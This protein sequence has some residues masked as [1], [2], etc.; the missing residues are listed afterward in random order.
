M[1]QCYQLTQTEL[2]N[3]LAAGYTLVGGPFNSQDECNQNCGSASGSAG[4]GSAGSG[5][6][7]SGGGSGGGG[8]GGGMS[9]YS[10][11][12]SGYGGYG[13]MFV[14]PV[15]EFYDSLPNNETDMP[16]VYHR[17]NIITSPKCCNNDLP[18]VLYLTIEHIVDGKSETLVL[19]GDGSMW[20]YGD[21]PDW[22]FSCVQT[23]E[24]VLSG[25]NKLRRITN[26][27]QCENVN[28]PMWSFKS[29]KINIT[30]T[31]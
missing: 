9:G 30:I 28:N 27:C 23:G 14:E 1:P 8:S 18:K 10:A 31:G 21:T 5:G 7:G 16:K 4:P 17:D 19:T 20:Y 6:G 3:L 29:D 11:S 2:N 25:P 15:G 24:L 12:G 26:D 13:M 22:L